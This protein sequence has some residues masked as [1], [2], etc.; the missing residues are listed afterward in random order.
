MYELTLALLYLSRFTEED[1]GIR[2]TRAR[3]GYDFKVLNNL[4]EDGYIFD[5]K[6][7]SRTKSIHISQEGLVKAKEILLKYN[8]KD[9]NEK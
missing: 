5:G 6:R 4:E 2:I 3:K 1:Y 9:W 8:I 7:P